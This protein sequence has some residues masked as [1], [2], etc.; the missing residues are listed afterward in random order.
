MIFSEIFNESDDVFCFPFSLSHFPFLERLRESKFWGNGSHLGSSKGS[1]RTDDV[2]CCADGSV[3]WESGPT[4]PCLWW[5]LSSV[6][7]LPILC[8]STPRITVVW[9]RVVKIDCSVTKVSVKRC[10]FALKRGASNVKMSLV[11]YNHTHLDIW[12]IS[13][14]QAN[15][16]HWV[17]LLLN[18][19]KK[20]ILN[21][22]CW[23]A[24]FQCERWI[25]AIESFFPPHL[26]WP[27]EPMD[28][29]SFHF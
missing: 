12:N 5:K 27:S 4:S 1:R 17:R 14:F 28:V 24:C 10:S 19:K 25:D 8:P 11:T 9:I 18:K 2:R 21:V 22:R 20:S 6:L 26:Q 23:S 3:C 13:T 15:T 16:H 7:H 29:W